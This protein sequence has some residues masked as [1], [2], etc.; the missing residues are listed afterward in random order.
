MLLQ[1][2]LL[3]ALLVPH[4]SI[5][6]EPF[7]FAGKGSTGP[8]GKY[9]V[10]F[11]DKSGVLT[12]SMAAS[13]VELPSFHSEVPNLGL[14]NS[15]H[16][17]M[18]D[19][20][21]Q[22]PDSHIILH[23]PHA[24]IDEIEVY[25]IDSVVP[26]P[27]LVGKAGLT[28][29]IA[30]RIQEDN[31]LSFRLTIR[32]GEKSTAILKVKSSKQL[33]VPVVLSTP[34]VHAQERITRN[35]YLGMFLGTMLVMALYNLFIYLSMRDKSYLLYVVYIVSV[36]LTQLA[37]SGT[38]PFYIWPDWTWFA[39][40][41]TVLLTILTAI[42]ATEFT[43]T[44]IQTRTHVPHLDKAIRPFYIGFGICIIL[45][46]SE[47]YLTAY[48][49]TQ[50]ISGVY[51]SFLL[52]LVFSVWRKGSRQAGFF[53]VAWSAFLIGT[54]V[55][56]LKDV[57]ILPYN[58]WTL[59]T[60]P[61]GAAIEGV[62]LSFG[63]ADRINVL[64]REKE[65]SQAQALAASLENER[66]I[67]EQNVILESKVK[68]RTAA[69]Q[70][71]NDTLKRTQ[72]H[73]VQSEKMASL[74]QLTAGIAHEINNPINFITSNI[75]P[76]RRDIADVVEMVQAWRNIPTEQAAQRV[77]ELRRKAD[78]IGLDETITELGEIVESIAEG[79]HRTAEIVRG[80]RNFSRLHEDDLKDMD[81][82]DGVRST[83]AVLTPQ[84]KDR[85][86][87]DMDL[88]IPVPVECFPGKVNQLLMNLLTNAA[89]ATLARP[90]DVER[91]VKITTRNTP[92]GV[93]VRISDN[94]IGMSPEVQARIFEPFFTTKPVGEGTGLGMAI[95]YGIVEEHHGTI[96]ITS[97]PNEGTTIA[98]GL[99]LRQPRSNQ[100]R[101]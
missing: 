60:M 83:L 15:Y 39:T 101:A 72:A 86:Q 12:P 74:G 19:I 93:E 50:L 68:E 67:R 77:E 71:S 96:S 42:M 51:A 44:F 80:L 49:L 99:P 64:R 23:V 94:G 18:M 79:S 43:R 57:G 26:E 36:A 65:A 89:Q 78:E 7:H 32:P 16:W 17:L 10:H 46:V 34:T 54:V 95:V 85:V 3:A 1:W 66:I 4:V 24:D 87:F 9:L 63:L 41:A 33:Q 30:E 82:N 37:F 31:E 20:V 6:Q 27:V 73:L 35:L 56:V 59:Y 92:D 28:I 98:M 11:E 100:R 40:K 91:R 90:G 70:E 88:G 61:M 84:F 45:Q 22:G 62:L 69:L 97:A 2:L 5:A 55:F 14:N 38:A 29:P 48:L 75:Q 53:L 13:L 81:I 21:N 58:S 76:L 52:Y 8:L 47:Q 25:Q